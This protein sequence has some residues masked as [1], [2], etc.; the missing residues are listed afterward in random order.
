MGWINGYVVVIMICS[1]GWAIVYYI[2]RVNRL[3]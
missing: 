2:M 3:H 1:M